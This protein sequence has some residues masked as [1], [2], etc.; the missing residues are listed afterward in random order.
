MRLADNER[1]EQEFTT[2]ES[3]SRLRFGVK[4]FYTQMYARSNRAFVAIRSG[5]A[6]KRMVSPWAFLIVADGYF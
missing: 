6:Q 1:R 4:G 3:R 2:G 5:N